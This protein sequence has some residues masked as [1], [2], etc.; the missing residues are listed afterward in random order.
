[1]VDGPFGGRVVDL[2]IVVKF[3]WVKQRGEFVSVR[4]EY[5]KCRPAEWA[6]QAAVIDYHNSV[7]DSDWPEFPFRKSLYLSMKSWLRYPGM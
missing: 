6:I 5:T 1:M 4:L 3:L 7:I 2:P